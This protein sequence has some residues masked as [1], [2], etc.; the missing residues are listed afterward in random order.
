MPKKLKKSVYWNIVRLN[1]D[2]GEY[3][4][5]AAIADQCGCSASVV[6]TTLARFDGPTGNPLP[7]SQ[8]PKKKDR[9]LGTVQN[10]FMIELL[11]QNPDM[12]IK[13][14]ADELHVRFPSTYFSVPRV[15]RALNDNQYSYKVLQRVAQ[16]QDAHERF[17]W[18]ATLLHC[19]DH[20][21]FVFID[22]S[23]FRNDNVRRTRGRSRRGTPC[24]AVSNLGRYQ[25]L[26]LI[27]AVT[28]NGMLLPAC[29]TYENGVNHSVLLQW[30]PSIC[31]QICL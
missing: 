15:C 20:S 26:S 1:F 27:A 16:E 14:I 2:W 13:E 12:Y 6:Q 3:E 21:R 25:Q 29:K 19:D 18:R 30:A 17:N 4:T 10:M 28:V 24:V 8:W 7:R 31:F 5:Q 11:N 9:R 22:E 23:H